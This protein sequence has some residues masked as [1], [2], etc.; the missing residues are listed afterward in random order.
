VAEA[1]VLDASPFILFAR[2]GRLDILRDI[3]PTIG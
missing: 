3:S 2:I 1:W